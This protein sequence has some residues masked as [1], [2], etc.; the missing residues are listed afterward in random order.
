MSVTKVR[1]NQMAPIPEQDDTA[2]DLSSA[3]VINGEKTFKKP[4]NL[5]PNTTT[6]NTGGQINFHYNQSSNATSYIVENAQGQIR[7]DGDLYLTGR[8]TQPYI[9]IQN[10]NIVCG[11]APSSNTNYEYGMIDSNGAYI[12]LIRSTYNTN[13]SSAITMRAFNTTIAQ[14]SGN[15]N[16]GQ[17]GIACDTSG[18]VFTVAPTPATTDNSTLLLENLNPLL[19]LLQIILLE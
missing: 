11:T 17:L 4:I 18:Q 10:K 6:A 9:N 2:V 5:Y 1:Y 16:I 7:V 15:S 19:P 13:K 14:N 3:Q 8:L 12:N